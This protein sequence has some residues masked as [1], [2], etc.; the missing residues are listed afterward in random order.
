MI[1]V[2][3]D[4]TEVVKLQVFYLPAALDTVGQFWTSIPWAPC[5]MEASSMWTELEGKEHTELSQNYQVK[6][7]GCN[8]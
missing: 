2:N 3:S 5:I 8:D 7:N 1:Q 4:L 6:I